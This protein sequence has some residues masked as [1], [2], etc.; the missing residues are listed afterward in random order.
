MRRLLVALL[1][2]AV[3]SGTATAQTVS[4]PSAVAF[5]AS[6]DHDVI[7]TPPPGE[8]GTAGPVLTTYLLEVREN[9]AVVRTTDLGKPAPSATRQI[10]V[11]LTM[12]GLQPT[13]TY[14][15]VIVAVGPGGSTPS[16]A[17][18]PFGWFATTPPPPAGVTNVTLLAGG[19]PSSGITVGGR[20]MAGSAGVL[21]R[22]APSLSSPSDIV[23]PTGALGTAIGGP[24][25]ADGYTWW[26]VDWDTG[27]DGWGT[28][29]PTF[30]TV[31]P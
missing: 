16:A 13:H 23:Q 21:V 4:N 6:V 15:A 1:G 27:A 24:T 9:S 5:V 22:P 3:V 20:V 30:L 7:W 11:S 28:E 31:A 10:V 29:G 17:T 2:L 14:T 26:D 25:V 8:S 12:T 19:V 18:V